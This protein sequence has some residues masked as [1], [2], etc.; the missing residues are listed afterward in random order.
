MGQ[1]FGT[2]GSRPQ[3]GPAMEQEERIPPDSITASSSEMS[4]QAAS[5]LDVQASTTKNECSTAGAM[6]GGYGAI[7]N[8]CWCRGVCGG[9]GEEAMAEDRRGGGQQE[10]KGEEG[11]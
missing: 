9:G 3:Y 11:S 10:G 5:P 4:A 8:E 6:S 2:L 1:N 7:H